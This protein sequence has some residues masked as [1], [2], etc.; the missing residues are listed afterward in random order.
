L[1]T[2]IVRGHANWALLKGDENLKDLA[3]RPAE[4]ECCHPIESG[5]QS[6]SRPLTATKEMGDLFWPATQNL[7]D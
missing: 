2:S 7:Q 6:R 4:E 5:R 1:F 3:V